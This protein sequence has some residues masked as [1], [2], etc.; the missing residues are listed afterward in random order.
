MRERALDRAAAAGGLRG[1]VLCIAILLCKQPYVPR[2]A[3]I[4]LGKAKFKGGLRIYVNI[5]RARDSACC[6]KFAIANE[7]PDPSSFRLIAERVNKQTTGHICA[8]KTQRRWRYASPHRPA[9]AAANPLLRLMIRSRDSELEPL[10]PRTRRRR[11]A[12]P[13][14]R[15]TINPN[16]SVRKILLNN[17]QSPHVSAA[18]KR[19]LFFIFFLPPPAYPPQR[20]IPADAARPVISRNAE[21]PARDL[22]A[23]PP[24]AP[25]ISDGF[26]FLSRLWSTRTMCEKRRLVSRA[27]AVMLREKFR[28]VER[29][30]RGGRF[31]E[32]SQ[33]RKLRL[34][35]IH[36]G[37]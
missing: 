24:R 32:M 22:S 33:I 2:I 1:G 34:E 29:R 16:N 28:V 14:A 27:R 3:R 8:G 5:T 17:Y 20:K 36:G 18:T 15:R 37:G 30:M 10:E 23:R 19:Y 31:C 26:F 11:G 7:P 12:P 25:L 4:G 35:F 21:S 9:S 13:S 6:G